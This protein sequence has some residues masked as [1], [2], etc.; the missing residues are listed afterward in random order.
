MKSVGSEE[1]QPVNKG[2]GLLCIVM[3]QSKASRRSLLLG[4][5]LH[6][7]PCTNPA[8]GA[9]YYFVHLP[10]TS[11]SLYSLNL[12]ANPDIPFPLV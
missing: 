1:D 7:F 10:E 12:I 8:Q 6:C 3:L 5:W 9:V 4:G 11:V 2:W